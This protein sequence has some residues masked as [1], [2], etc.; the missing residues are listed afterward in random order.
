MKSTL[1]CMALC[2][3]LFACS[4][5]EVNNDPVLGVWYNQLD[6][7]TQKSTNTA[8]VEEWTFNDAYYGRYH[9]YKNGVVIFKTDYM[10]SI[11]NGIYSLT[12]HSEEMSDV[13]F[14]KEG[15]VLY[16]VDGD[17]MATREE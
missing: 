6:I 8:T 1:F 14:K 10:W 7:A 16:E 2:L 3:C 5:P 17:I 15:T 13:H 4:K 9:Q 11:E 12:Y